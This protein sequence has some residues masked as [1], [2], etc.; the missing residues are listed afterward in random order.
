MG[1]KQEVRIVQKEKT[2]CFTGHRTMPEGAALNDLEK[3]IKNEIEISLKDGYNRFLFGAAIGF[4][5]LCGELLMERKKKKFLRKTIVFEVVAVVPFEEQAEKYSVNDQ[6]RYEVLLA[7]CDD[8]IVLNS[9]YKNGCYKQRNQ[10]MVDN[11]SKID[12]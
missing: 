5:M 1:G 9:H 12:S 2:V 8:V 4:D 10:Y 7:K 6:N 11:S 3:R